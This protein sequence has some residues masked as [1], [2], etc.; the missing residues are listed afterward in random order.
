MPR[1]GIGNYVFTY[2]LTFCDLDFTSDLAF[3]IAA[4]TVWGLIPYGT[5][6]YSYFRIIRC[7]LQSRRRVRQQ[8]RLEDRTAISWYSVTRTEVQMTKMSFFICVTF[9]CTWGPVAI[10]GAS[11]KFGYNFDHRFSLIAVIFMYIGTAVNPFI[12]AFMKGPYKKELTR[13]L[14]RWKTTVSMRDVT[15][16]VNTIEMYWLHRC[17]LRILVKIDENYSNLS[18]ECL[19]SVTR[20]ITPCPLNGVCIDSCIRWCRPGTSQLLN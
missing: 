9:V 19:G 7:V 6:Y 3:S 13:L 17:C 14:K 10:A 15:V 16:N 8:S 20:N 1:V 12:Y 4:L 5:I 2:D 18:I 11:P